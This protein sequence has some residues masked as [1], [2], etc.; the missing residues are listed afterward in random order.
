MGFVVLTN[1]GLR[2]MMFY[3]VT[4]YLMNIGAF[5]VVMIVANAPGARTSTPIAAWL[6]A[7]ARRRR[8][9]WRCSC[10]R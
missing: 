4:Y 7:A 5:L 1:D 2:A 6:G 3:L 10:S 8:W 9:R